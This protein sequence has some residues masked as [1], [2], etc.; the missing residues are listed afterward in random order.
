MTLSGRNNRMA[1]CSCH[2]LVL[3]EAYNLSTQDFGRASSIDIN[4]S[5]T[6]SLSIINRLSRPL[7]DRTPASIISSVISISSRSSQLPRVRNAGRSRR[8][9]L[10]PACTSAPRLP[11]INGFQLIMTPIDA[12]ETCADSHPKVYLSGSDWRLV[13]AIVA[14]AVK[15][16]CCPQSH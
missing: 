5:T 8:T 4:I 6:I 3:L 7:Y 15:S 16:G 9:R 10:A 14:S 11:P 2:F 1:F 12:P 13:S